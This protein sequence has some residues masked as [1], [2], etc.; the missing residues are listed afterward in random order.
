MQLK[1]K[2]I[3][4]K[5]ADVGDAEFILNLRKSEKYN[6][7]LSKTEG[8]LTEQINWLKNYKIR[9]SLNEEYYFIIFRGADNEKIGTVR[10]YDFKESPLSFCWGSWILNEKKTISSAIESALL[11]YQF[12]F[13]CKGFEQSHFDVRNDNHKVIDFH[14][15]LGAQEVSK[16]ELNTYFTF[17]KN[18]YQRIYASYSKFLEVK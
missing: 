3:F 5:L 8:C 10:L 4:L 1:S 9:E 13:D 15:K 11:I 14:K 7:Y 6:K 16:N 2:S 18:T 12:A 17:S